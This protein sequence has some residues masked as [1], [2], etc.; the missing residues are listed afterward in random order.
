MPHAFWQIL[1]DFEP[2]RVHL[3]RQQ[4][5]SCEEMMELVSKTTAVICSSREVMCTVDDIL[6]RDPWCQGPT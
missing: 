2:E 1:A 4:T 3:D 6:A 5:R